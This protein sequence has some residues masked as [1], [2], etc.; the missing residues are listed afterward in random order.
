VHIRS[1]TGGGEN[2]TAD[3]FRDELVS[4]AEA[5]LARARAGDE[6]AFSALTDPYRSELQLHC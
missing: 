5:A 4:L 1:D 3:P 6:D 2:G